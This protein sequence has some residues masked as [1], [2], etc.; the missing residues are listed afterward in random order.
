MSDTTPPANPAEVPLFP[1]DPSG[2]DRHHE[3][4]LMR[5]L[6]PVIRA[7]LPGDVAMWVVTDYQLLAELSADPRI[8]RDWRTWEALRKGEIPDDWPLLSM[9]RLNNLM[10]R[11]GAEHRRLRRPL[12]K[13]FTRS[14]VERM[15]PRIDEIVTAMLDDLPNQA[16]ADG[17]VDL[18]KHYAYP[19]PMQVICELIG[20]PEQWWSRFRELIDTVI[21]TDTTPEQFLASQAERHDYF[22]QLFAMRRKNPTDDLTSALLAA[23]RE[24]GE[25]PFTDEELEDTLWTLIGAGHETSISL[26]VNATRALL[27]HPDQHNQVRGG[28]M[29]VWA[30]VVEETLRYDSPVGN[31][32]ARFPTEDITI[33][34]ITIPKGDAILAPWSGVNRDPKQYGDTADQFDINRPVKRHLAFGTGPHICIGPA[35]ARFE[36]MAALPP[37]FNRYPNLTLATNPNNLMPVP[38]IFSNSVTGLPVHLGPRK[39]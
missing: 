8:G 14:R 39:N 3:S 35:L 11:D 38:S 33:A 15:G 32:P 18:R 37:L 26:I 23:D 1:I 20:V 28:D 4:A 22:Q 31:F 29:A 30:E 13:A 19:F 5:D 12:T 17:T 7:V 6:G 10:A 16:E 2:A 27:T 24:A 21:R 34:G 36:A 9:I 25:E